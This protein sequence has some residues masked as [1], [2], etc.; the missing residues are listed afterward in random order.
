MDGLKKNHYIW[1]IIGMA[2]F[3]LLCVFSGYK[4]SS[5]R[6]KNTATTDGI[7]NRLI[8][9]QQRNEELIASNAQ[10][11]RELAESGRELGELRGVNESALEL[12]ER[13]ARGFIELTDTLGSGGSDIAVLIQ[14]QR[15]INSIVIRLKEE[16]RQSID[17][18][19]KGISASGRNGSASSREQ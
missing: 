2:I 12:A 4:V 18:L 5:S 15:A 14:R 7:E 10:L 19:R 8:A 17:T 16:N 13:S 11:V 1:L 9:I 3:G 6:Y